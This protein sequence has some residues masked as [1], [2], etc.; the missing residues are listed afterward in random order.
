MP[1]IEF[2]ER[3]SDHRESD[4]NPKQSYSQKGGSDSTVSDY[5]EENTVPELVKDN[6]A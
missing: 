6:K 4:S 1:K 5:S 2:G 3:Y